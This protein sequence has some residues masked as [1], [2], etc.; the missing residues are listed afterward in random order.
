MMQK[1][2]VT[3]CAA[4]MLVSCGGKKSDDPSSGITKETKA[5]LQI[6]DEK[7]LQEL[8]N[9]STRKKYENKVV[10]M[11]GYIKSFKKNVTTAEPNKYSFFLCS[12]INQEDTYCTICY[13]ENEPSAFAGKAVTVKGYFDYAGMVSLADCVVY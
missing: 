7:A 5:D 8:G 3:L 2:F 13:I 10:E 1:V 12:D 6:S 9:D 11:K 4:I